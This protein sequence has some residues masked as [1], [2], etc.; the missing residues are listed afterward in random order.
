MCP[1]VFGTMSS[2]T[3]MVTSMATVIAERTTRPD[4]FLGLQSNI[5]TAD[6]FLKQ[7]EL[8]FFNDHRVEWLN[9]EVVEMAAQS[10]W[11][12][13]GLSA[14]QYALEE[15]FP[16]SA[17]WI[18]V[19]NTLDLRPLGIP[20][21]DIAVVAG[22]FHDWQRQGA[23]ANPTMAVLIV[24]VA[25]TTLETDRIRKAS[26]YAAAGIPEYWVLNLMDG[27]LELFRDPVADAS[28]EFG[29]R[30]ANVINIDRTGTVAPLHVPTACIAVEQLLPG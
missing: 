6:E 11:H 4:S 3:S 21:P 2:S 22:S 18:R 13:I 16:K 14:G 20:D 7:V 29:H 1:F 19:Q 25:D 27:Q 17:Y 15:I 9:G 23:R 30:Y 12:A 8:G 28:T 10:N 5:L 26:L 24:E